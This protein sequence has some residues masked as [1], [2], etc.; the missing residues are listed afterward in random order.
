MSG[1]P[2]YKFIVVGSS[3]VGKTAILKRLVEDTFTDDSLSTIGVEFDSTVVVVDNNKVKLQIWDTAGQERFRSIAKAY[4]RN[5]AG[6]FVVY[7]LTDR[8]SFDDLNSWMSDI[9]ALCDANAVVLLIANKADLASRRVVTV[10]EAERFAAHH[11]IMYMETSAKLGANVREAFVKV[12]AAILGKKPGQAP[13][14]Q[15][16]KQ[17]PLLATAM[18]TGAEPESKSCC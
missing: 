1:I 13:P 8:P 16:A 12:T 3:G 4:Y 7:D 17:S 15:V 18:P 14:S 2:T 6:V 10:A 5:A 11:R 9:H